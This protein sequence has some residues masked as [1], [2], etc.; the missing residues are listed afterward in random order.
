MSDD[1]EQNL[2]RIEL[3]AR[4]TFAVMKES[5]SIASEVLQKLRV[6][7]PMFLSI[8]KAFVDNLVNIHLQG[9]DDEQT[10]SFMKLVQL[11]S[12]VI[13]QELEE[14]LSKLEEEGLFTRRK[15]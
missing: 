10:R 8:T 4:A 9:S 12:D 13:K 7:E 3:Q 1:R 5:F 11:S 15:G 2:A 6:S 14:T